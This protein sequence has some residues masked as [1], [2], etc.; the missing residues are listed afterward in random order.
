MAQILNEAPEFGIMAQKSSPHRYRNPVN[1]A[2]LMQPKHRFTSLFTSNLN[3]KLNP[4]DL[5]RSDAAT[6][7]ATTSSLDTSVVVADLNELALDLWW[8]FNNLFIEEEDTVVTVIVVVDD[9]AFVVVVEFVF[10]F[11]V[12]VVVVG[13]QGVEAVLAHVQG[14]MVIS[15][16]CHLQC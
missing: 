12:V 16:V 13:I 9:E 10:V 1:P 6:A 8:T 2:F 4:S 11:V 3:L 14:I 7:V 5:T 15:L